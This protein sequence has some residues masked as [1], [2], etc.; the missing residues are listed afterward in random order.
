MPFVTYQ[1]FLWTKKRETQ[2]K[3]VPMTDPGYGHYPK[4]VY[5]M[6]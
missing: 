3:S 6:L 5:L 1:G 2:L 4:I